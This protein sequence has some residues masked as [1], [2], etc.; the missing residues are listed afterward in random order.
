MAPA[1]PCACNWW[2]RRGRCRG[3]LAQ[4]LECAG[5][6]HVL[7][8]RFAPCPGVTDNRPTP[9][10]GPFIRLDHPS[11]GRV[12]RREPAST[13]AIRVDTEEEAEVED[14]PTDLRRVADHDGLAGEVRAHFG[15]VDEFPTELRPADSV[16]RQP[17]VVIGVDEDVGR[18]L[19]IVATAFD[20]SDMSIGIMS[21]LPW[22]S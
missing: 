15:P 1:P 4:L 12:E 6:L 14:L 17:V 16:H 13:A 8:G 7:T 20:E 2:A 9:Q 22:Y 19:V 5:M 18:G 3:P 11:R 21:D 10:F